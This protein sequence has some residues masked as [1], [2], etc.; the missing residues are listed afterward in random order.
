MSFS[1]LLTEFIDLKVQGE[2]ECDW[3]SID[4]RSRIRKAYHDRID[5][6][7]K[8]IDEMVPAKG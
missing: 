5:E 8:Q 3:V 4:E 2:P 6:I 1:E 7:K